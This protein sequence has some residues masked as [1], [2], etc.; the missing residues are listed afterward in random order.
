VRKRLAALNWSTFRSLQRTAAPCRPAHLAS[1]QRRSMRATATCKHSAPAFAGRPGHVRHSTQTK[2]S[3]LLRT[4]Q[5]LSAQ[6][7]IDSLAQ[8]R[9]QPQADVEVKFAGASDAAAG[10]S[11]AELAMAPLITHA[12]IESL[13]VRPA[14]C[15]VHAASSQIYCSVHDGLTISPVVGRSAT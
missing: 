5:A 9:Q 7:F 1:S 15:R 6:P 2:A 14:T 13:E 3:Q 12:A 10:D 4:P 8:G 11:A